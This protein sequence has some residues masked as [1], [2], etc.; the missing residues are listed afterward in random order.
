MPVFVMS[1]GTVYFANGLH[2][3]YLYS[4]S[5]GE[6]KHNY[7]LLRQKNLTNTILPQLYYCGSTLNSVKQVM[8]VLLVSY[9]R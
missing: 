8:E 3:S 5:A 2:N 9:H 1:D 4:L 7:S 6:L